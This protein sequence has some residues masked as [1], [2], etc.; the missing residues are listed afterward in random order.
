MAEDVVVEASPESREHRPYYKL[1]AWRDGSAK[2]I[3]RAVDDSNRGGR[4]PIF[5]LDTGNERRK[6]AKAFAVTS[7]QRVWEEFS[8]REPSERC[9]YE[10]VLHDM[11]CHLHVDVDA[12]RT[13]NPRLTRASEAELLREFVDECTRMLAA[14][15]GE[16]RPD[17]IRVVV[18]ES[19]AGA[20]LSLHLLFRVPGRM[21][22]NNYHCGAFVRRLRDRFAEKHGSDLASNRMFVRDGAGGFAFL[23]DLS[24]YTKRRNFRVLGASKFGQTDRPLLP[25]GRDKRAPLVKREFL[26]ALVQRPD[27]DLGTAEPA[28]FGCDEASGAVPRSTNRI[29]VSDGPTAGLLAHYR[30]AYPFDAVFLVAGGADRTF[31]FQ[32]VEKRWIRRTGFEDAAAFRRAVLDACPA[33]IHLGARGGAR[34]RELVFDL[35][36]TDYADVRRCCGGAKKACTLCWKYA[37]F[38]MLA[39]R[40]ALS[41]YGFRAVFFF[42]S[43]RRG[44][45]CWVFDRTAAALTLAARKAIL[46][47][48]K[49]DVQRGPCAP[50]ARRSAV[51]ELVRA[52]DASFFERA[53]REDQGLGAEFDREQARI[54]REGAI[55]RFFW[56]RLDEA[57]TCVRDHNVKT[58]FSPHPET[59]LACW[60]LDPDSDR[61]PFSRPPSA[62]EVA[63]NARRFS[64]AVLASGAF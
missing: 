40:G 16:T 22:V 17:R 1:F 9:F 7:Y 53:V 45:H 29:E 18:L 42:F 57:V 35:D 46:D 51:D 41:D 34:G 10:I 63:E 3:R 62:D 52:T 11:P 15:A 8:A 47:D 32:T 49:L 4:L 56:P 54:G 31:W 60:M 2:P 44:F 25:P 5:A 37:R 28:L 58:P 27:P 33:A 61:D 19:S 39:L 6:G 36:L 21:F 20:K 30:D 48:L 26:G 64:A 13:A 24:I 55:L 59:G 12:C 14:T 23:A 38:G 50:R 43:G